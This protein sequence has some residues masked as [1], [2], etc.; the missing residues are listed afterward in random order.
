MYLEHLECFYKGGRDG[1]DIFQMHQTLPLFV[2]VHCQQLCM[3]AV[4]CLYEQ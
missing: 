2:R 3:K 4:H 1:I